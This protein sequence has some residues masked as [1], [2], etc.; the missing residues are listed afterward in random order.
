M[1]I[2]SSVALAWSEIGTCS[3]CQRGPGHKASSLALPC[4]AAGP[5]T[6]AGYRSQV[7][8]TTL[9][10]SS[11]PRLDRVR[12]PLSA[13]P[14]RDPRVRA[15]AAVASWP[16][17]GRIS[18]PAAPVLGAGAGAGAG[19][20]RGVNLAFPSTVRLHLHSSTQEGPVLCCQTQVVF[21]VLT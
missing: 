19:S 16:G 3:Q 7:A 8:T 20:L 14:T 2:A 15:K 1:P 21:L 9:T 10:E 4:L 17:K 18:F 5:S 12:G 11:R 6:F 13:K